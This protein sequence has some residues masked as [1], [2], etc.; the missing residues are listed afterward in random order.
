MLCGS[1]NICRRTSRPDVVVNCAAYNFVDKAEAEPDAAFAVNAW[2]VR[3]LARACRE[4]GSRLVQF[5][6]DYVFGLD[7]GRSSPVSESDAPGPVSVYG[8]SKL[9]GEYAVLAESPDFLVIRTCGL[10]GVW[11]SG[12][13]GGNFVETMLR[14]AGQGKPL[15]V[16]ADQRC[17]P[18]YT[19]DIAD[20][21]VALID[22]GATG[23]L[24]LTNAGDCSW[25]DLA[26]EIFSRAG[27][28]ADLTPITSEEF[29]APAKRPHYSVLS[30][31]R[32]RELGVPEPRSWKDALG[33]YLAERGK[34]DR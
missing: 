12:G 21:T 25:H 7:A 23:L 8:M 27:V 29:A 19:A 15:R 1:V 31:A 26:A 2:A 9:C 5:S 22:R 24:H 34:R 11:G 28:E 17:T 4:V 18:S 20:A 10:Y 32:L 3:D 16:V 13:K 6:T 33:A 14:V 30:M